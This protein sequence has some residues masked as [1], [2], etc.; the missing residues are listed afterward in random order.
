MKLTNRATGRAGEFLACSIL[1]NHGIKSNH[2]DLDGDDLWAKCPR[3]F[4]YPI[5][6]KTATRP[7]I[8]ARHHKIAKYS[9]SFKNNMNYVGIFVLCAL[10][11]RK[12]ICM[13]WDDIAATTLKIHPD[14]FT[15]EAEVQSIKDVFLL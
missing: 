10:D 2:V 7:L 13:K 4:F 11:K 6:V 14:R 3:N 5:Q 12:I 1:E 15:S 9:F 8:N